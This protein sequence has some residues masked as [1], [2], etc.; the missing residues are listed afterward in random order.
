MSEDLKIEI[1]KLWALHEATM[2]LEHAARDIE[3][4]ENTWQVFTPSRFI[5]AF[6]AFNS[7]YDIDWQS[8]FDKQKV[9]RWQPEEKNIN[10]K[11]NDR[12]QC[13]IPCRIIENNDRPPKEVDQIKYYIKYFNDKLVS[14]APNRFAKILKQ[15]LDSFGITDPVTALKDIDLVNANN[16]LERQS[17]IVPV[18]FSLVLQGYQEPDDFYSSVVFLIKFVYKV[19]CNLFHGTKTMVHL[20]N[21]EQQKRLLIYTALLI[22][23]NSLLFRVAE[24]ADIRWEK[25]PVNFYPSERN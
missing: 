10:N 2:R 20:L 7:I 17:K 25:V 16:K 9:I 5:Y 23:A 19:R 6:F 22:S 24:K 4:P 18:Q 8:S 21:Q 3:C 13:I 11:D 14:E 15:M 1:T 12:L